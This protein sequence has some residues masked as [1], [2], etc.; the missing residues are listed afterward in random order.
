MYAVQNYFV[1]VLSSISSRIHY[2]CN[3]L[4]ESV[5]AV[6]KRLLLLVKQFMN[7]QDLP[8]ILLNEMKVM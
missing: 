5:L 8:R 1:N 2:T 4:S 7:S 6:I 3:K